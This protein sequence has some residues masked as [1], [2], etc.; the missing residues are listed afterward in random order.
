M[1][2][3]FLRRDA[4]KQHTWVET[5]EQRIRGDLIET[6]KKILIDRKTISK[7]DFLADHTNGRAYT[8]VLR[9][10]VAVCRL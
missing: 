4:E 1:H 8:T 10:W 6:F 2:F 7:P 3:Y 5:V 9:Q